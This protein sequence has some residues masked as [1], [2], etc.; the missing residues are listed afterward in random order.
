MEITFRQF[1]LI[2]HL[3]MGAL[4]L[5]SFVFGVVAL[6]AGEHV[7]RMRKN[8][9]LLAGVA[10]LTVVTG[11]WIVYPWYSAEEGAK[12]MSLP[13]E[14][15]LAHPHLLQWHE[16][17]MEWKE[18]VGWFSPI[19][20]TA[21]AYLV[22]R[23]GGQLVRRPEIRRAAIILFGA[24]FFAALVAGVFGVLLNKV[25]PNLFLNS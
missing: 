17:G 25:A 15:L 21:V 9:W 18:H 12:L 24:S 2:V 10:W 23:Y 4:L 19:L 8:T 1:W 14:Y 11:T 13:K 3:G 20:A 5:H 22:M 6:R 7:W 16:F